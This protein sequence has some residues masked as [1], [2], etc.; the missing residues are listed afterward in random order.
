MDENTT[1]KSSGWNRIIPMLIL[2]VSF[3][4]AEAVLYL[5]AVIQFIWSLIDGKRNEQLSGFGFSLAEWMAQDAK[6]LTYATEEKPFPW[7]KWPVQEETVQ[8]D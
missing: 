2:I 6:F 4:I 7:G 3:S 8:S 5:V 1:E